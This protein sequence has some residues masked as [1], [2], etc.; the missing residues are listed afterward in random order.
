MKVK[1]LKDHEC[2][3]CGETIRKGAI[4]FAFMVKPEKPDKNEFDVVYTCLKYS[5]EEACRVRIRQK[6][7]VT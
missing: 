7:A 3:C 6:G 4:C 5:E 2:F 1:A